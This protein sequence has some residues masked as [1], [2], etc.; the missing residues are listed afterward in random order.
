[1]EQEDCADS[2]K[3][4]AKDIGCLYD[5]V[6]FRVFQIR[7]DADSAQ[8]NEQQDGHGIQNNR[9]YHISAG[10]ECDQG[11]IGQQ[12]AGR[13]GQH[14]DGIDF[15]RLVI[16]KDQAGNDHQDQKDQDGRPD[17]H[18]RLEE[19]QP[20]QQDSGIYA[21]N[22]S[23]WHPELNHIQPD[24]NLACRDQQAEKDRNT[25]PDQEENPIRRLH[26]GI[27][28]AEQF[29]HGNGIQDRIDVIKQSQ[30][31]GKTVELLFHFV[32]FSKSG[33]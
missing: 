10:G 33:C 15:F 7:L 3:Q 32:S 27:S 6:N 2:N 4:L 12:I 24:Q 13:S 28:V 14:G 30:R 21:E 8:H 22:Q 29:D 18:H 31:Y 16:Q 11:N 20:G 1:M 25:C 23:D 19:H 26:L 5:P 9:E 17:I